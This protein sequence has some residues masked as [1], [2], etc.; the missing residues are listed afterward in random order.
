MILIRGG[1]V[2]GSGGLKFPMGFRGDARAGGLGDRVPI[3]WSIFFCK[4]TSSYNYLRPGEN[5]L[6]NIL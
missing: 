5:K 3:S 2:M 4:C 1:Q 6:Q